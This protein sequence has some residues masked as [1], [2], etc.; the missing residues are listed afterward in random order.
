[1]IYEIKQVAQCE[2]AKF[3]PKHAGGFF[4]TFENMLF[5]VA[6]NFSESYKGGHWDF[7]ECQAKA[8]TQLES[9]SE[10]EQ[11]FFFLVP[12]GESYEVLNPNN[13]FEGELSGEAYGVAV[14]L[15]TLSNYLFFVNDKRRQAKGA[16]AQALSEQQD[17]LND[18][19]YALRSY[20][21]T[22]PEAALINQFI[23]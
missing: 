4:M 10:K 21:Q 18:A 14:T 8:E 17:Y 1:M 11:G 20:A 5:N 3:L 6:G 9:L 23:D 16:I 12:C 19:F 13:Y 15:I 7:K 2:R 22:L